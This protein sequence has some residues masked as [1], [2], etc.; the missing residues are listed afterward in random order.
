MSRL[1]S[2]D[3]DPLT[4]LDFPREIGLKRAMCHDKNQWDSYV[5]VL[6]TKSSCYTSLYSFKE[7][8]DGRINYDTVIIDRAWWDFDSNDDYTIEDVKDDVALLLRR[9]EGDVRLVATGRG[10]HIH[11]LFKTPV[12]GK[13]WMRKLQTYEKH[14]AR[15]LKTLDGVGFPEKLTRIPGTYNPKRNRWSVPIDPQTFCSNPQGFKIPKTPKNEHK[16]YDPFVGVGRYDGFDF[17]SWTQENHDVLVV[18]E[19]DGNIGEVTDAGLVPMIP[20]IERA[21]NVSNPAHHVRVALVQHMAEHLRDFVD[22]NT[23]GQSELIE[24]ENSIFDYIKGL[25]WRDF[26]PSRTRQGIRTNIRYSNSPTCG[27]FIS[28]G[29]CPGKCWRYD[30]SGRLE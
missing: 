1:W 5:R 24:I 19:P 10:F 25:G 23:L 20:C 28:R 6:G 15:G 14:M 30:G 22:P 7:L 17:T 3:G 21:I 4:L 27:W 9:L 18:P 16:E 13:I 26:K 11:Q 29:L 8:K 12:I 2:Q